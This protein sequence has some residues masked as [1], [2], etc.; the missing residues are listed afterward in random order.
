[1]AREPTPRRRQVL[2]TIPSAALLPGLAS[3]SAIAGSSRNRGNSV[4]SVSLTEIGLADEVTT[5]LLEGEIDH[6]RRLLDHHDVEHA[7]DISPI[8]SN[9]GPG[10]NG[11]YSGSAS[12]AGASLVLYEDNDIYVAS[13]WI[14]LRDVVNDIRDAAVVDDAC[15]IVYDSSEWSS[16]NPTED[17]VLLT[18]P[19]PHNLEYDHY[20]P[21]HGAAAKMSLDFFYWPDSSVGMQ[22]KLQKTNPDDSW[23]PVKFEYDH[24]WAWANNYAGS[25][26]I[27]L[28]GGHLSVSLPTGSSTAWNA[29]ATAYV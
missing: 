29:E 23:V 17:G 19:E 2:K 10:L 3:H 24:T 11:R 22:T 14:F 28:A 13:G 6:A 12:E 8:R 18:D 4:G 15:A 9:D 26:S 20:N 21:N 16:I 1:M 5:L 25:I 27:S 7:I